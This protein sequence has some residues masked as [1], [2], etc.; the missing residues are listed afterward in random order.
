M[1]GRFDEAACP[2]ALFLRL[3]DDVNPTE[4]LQLMVESFLGIDGG[5]RWAARDRPG[6][7][8]I[9]CLRPSSSRL[10]CVLM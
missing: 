4:A 8:R 10:R 7:C 2:L 5:A 1:A 9:G 6:S 3:A